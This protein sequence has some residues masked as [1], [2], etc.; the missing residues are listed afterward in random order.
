M[1]NKA[2]ARSEAYNGIWSVIIW[3][4]LKSKSAAGIH[5]NLG[6][7]T[8]QHKPHLMATLCEIFKYSF[9]RFHL[10]YAA[11]IKWD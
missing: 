3:I 8:E 2:N 9:V 7:Y 11:A 10:I 4:L 6:S 5:P 1:E